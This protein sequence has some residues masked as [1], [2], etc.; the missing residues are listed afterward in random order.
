MRRG[1]QGRWLW[2]GRGGRRVAT[3]GGGCRD[4]FVA[5]WAEAP[6]LAPLGISLSVLHGVREED[7]ASAL[8]SPARPVLNTAAQV[9][10][11][12][13]AGG[14]ACD[15]MVDT[16]MNRLGVAPGDVVDGL[17]DGIAIDTLM[18]HLACADDDH[19]MNERQRARFAGLAD[20][21]AARRL[22]LAN[23]SGVA[24]GEGYAFD[25]T[26]PGLALY[27]G[28]PRAEFAG[29]IRP[30]VVSRSAGLA[31]TPRHGRRHGGL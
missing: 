11:W 10:R 3:G 12:R 25:L 27:G 20:R 13:A 23:S 19:A 9:A 31:A 1:G 29:V 8:A 4:F 24:L 14:G 22:S 5:G 30:V 16:G 26:R 2:A 21:T 18:S 6:A 17:L 28:V 7:M 15:V